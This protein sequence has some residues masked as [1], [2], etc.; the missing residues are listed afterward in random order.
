MV[1][2]PGFRGRLLTIRQQRHYS[3]PLQ[4]TDNRP[5]AVVAPPGP[6]VDADDGRPLHREARTPAH[7]TQQRVVAHGHYEALGEPRAR[8][9]AEREPEMMDKALQPH[10]APCRRRQ[11]VPREAFREYLSPTQNRSVAE[12]PGDDG[13]A[14]LS[15]AKRKVHRR[16]SIM[17]MHASR[18]GPTRRT[19]PGAAHVPYDDGRLACIP[20]DVLNDEPSRN[21]R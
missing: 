12:S 13:Q 11:H 19:N 4:I 7:D 6:V 9:S 14:D 20:N 17:A 18:G 5:I 2:E 3:P 15:S 21:D 8:S 16:P 1:G 10:G